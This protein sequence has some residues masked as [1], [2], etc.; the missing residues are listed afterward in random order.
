MPLIFTYGLVAQ[1]A[2]ALPLHN[3]PVIS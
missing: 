1:L 3:S 2:R